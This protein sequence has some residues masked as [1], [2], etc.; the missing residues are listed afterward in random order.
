MNA[1]KNNGV[2]HINDEEDYI[3]VGVFAPMHTAT[4]SKW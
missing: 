2:K 1:L 3:S 4:K